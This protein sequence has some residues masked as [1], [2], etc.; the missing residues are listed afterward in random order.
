MSMLSCYITIIVSLFYPFFLIKLRV[1]AER[2]EIYIEQFFR[3]R[4]FFR[5]KLT[6]EVQY[7][8]EYNFSSEFLLLSRDG[9]LNIKC[10]QSERFHCVKFRFA[11]N[12]KRKYW[13][14]ERWFLEILI[15][16]L[17]SHS[18]QCTVDQKTLETGQK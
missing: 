17:F 6:P 9:A 14:F 13:I 16:Y 11:F 10:F 5:V 3:A 12:N 8:S 15:L 2:N 18:L 1:Y 4:N 7:P